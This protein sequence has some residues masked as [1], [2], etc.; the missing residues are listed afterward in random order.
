MTLTDI[1][2]TKIK[3]LTTS[4]IFHPSNTLQYAESRPYEI[5]TLRKFKTDYDYSHLQLLKS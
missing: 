2:S 3:Y 1:V 5:L 4:Y